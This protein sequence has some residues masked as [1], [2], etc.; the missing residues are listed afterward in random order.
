M[1]TAVAQSLSSPASPGSRKRRRI[2][3]E[4]LHPLFQETIRT[5]RTQ[6]QRLTQ[7]RVPA[8]RNPTDYLEFNSV[9]RALDDAEDQIQ[10]KDIRGARLIEKHLE[11]ARSSLN[12]D[13]PWTP[14]LTFIRQRLT[15]L[16][17][18]LKPIAAKVPGNSD[19]MHFTE[20]RQVALKLQEASE[21]TQSSDVR[22]LNHADR[23]CDKI[24]PLLAGLKTLR[25]WT[26]AKETLPAFIGEARTKLD[27]KACQ[28]ICFEF[29]LRNPEYFS[30]FCEATESLN[31]LET[32]LE[33]NEVARLCDLYFI[34]YRSLQNA[35]RAE[36]WTPI[37]FIPAA[38]T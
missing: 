18:Q 37:R 7:A 17:T 34:A 3:K 29:C 33:K 21:L 6:L 14:T 11:P 16:S 38:R 5:L 28:L 12:P 35:L 32:A 36:D 26:L 31:E 15:A 10:R 8:S 27:A 25:S 1:A 13:S 22:S 4:T 30:E 23:L 9:S 24:V 19:P 2:A 20:Y